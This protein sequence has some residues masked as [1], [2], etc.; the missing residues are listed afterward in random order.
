MATLKGYTQ[1]YG[2]PTVRKPV[3]PID[4]S[5]ESTAR[6]TP[7]E[8]LF[9]RIKRFAR[10][11]P[12]AVR[13]I[14]GAIMGIPGEGGFQEG[15]QGGLAG[16][17]KGFQSYDAEQKQARDEA[18]KAQMEMEKTQL[19]RR[20]VAL[21]E[22]KYFAPNEKTDP[23]AVAQR[24]RE[25]YLQWLQGLKPDQL[26]LYRGWRPRVGAGI[27]SDTIAQKLAS[28]VTQTF[29]Q[30]T[31]EDALILTRLGPSTASG[32]TLSVLRRPRPDEPR[33][34][35]YVNETLRNPVRVPNPISAAILRKY[36]LDPVKFYNDINYEWW[37]Q[38]DDN[39]LGQGQDIPDQSGGSEDQSFDQMIDEST[40]L[41][42]LANWAAAPDASEEEYNRIL[43]R[44]K[45]LGDPDPV[46]HV[47]RIMGPAERS[48]NRTGFSPSQVDSMMREDAIRGLKGGGR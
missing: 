27:R 8:D 41:E 20:R 45:S 22:L 34:W 40:D 12:R 26:A 16:T 25:A 4:L 38:L 6:E 28:A 30:I 17:L 31:S 29:P 24:S 44:M 36:G 18:L 15:L 35:A 32:N 39:G 5:Q 19:D 21:D 9:Q 10:E 7:P 46:G 11:N 14:V 2:A 3:P 13:G 33:G 42:E 47:D 1:P 37:K 43:D 48:K 23:V